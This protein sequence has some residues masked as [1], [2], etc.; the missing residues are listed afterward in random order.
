MSIEFIDDCDTCINKITFIKQFKNI[1]ITHGVKKRNEFL[2][3]TTNGNTRKV[4][5]YINCTKTS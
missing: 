5:K 4:P 1:M 2:F 3:L